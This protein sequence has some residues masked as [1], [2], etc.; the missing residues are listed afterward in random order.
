MCIAPHKIADVGFVACRECWQ[1]R[2]RKVDDWVG[3]CIA[4]G[5]TA[6]AC[7]AVTLTY[8]DDLSTGAKDHQR[9]TVLTYSDVQKY[10]KYLRA[11]GY[12]VRYMA[13]GE[14]GSIK[15]RAHWHIILYWQDRVPEHEIGKRF[16]QKHWPHGFSYWEPVSAQSI[17]Y[18]C[19]YIQKDMG[20]DLRQG[21]MAM[22]KKP[23]LGDA[24]FRELA[25]RY[26]ENGIAPQD[27]FYS[28]PEVRRVPHGTKGKSAK[29]FHANSKP[30]Q[31]MMSGKTADNFLTY[32]VEGWREKFNDE[33]PR[34][35]VVWAWLDKNLQRYVDSI[36]LPR[37]ERRG[38]VPK[39]EKPP[40]GGSAVRFDEGA[41]CFY[42]D[43]HGVRMFYSYDTE[44]DLGWH[45]KI[46]PD[47]A[48]E[49][50]R[51]VQ[52]EAAQNRYLD[53]S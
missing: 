45:E 42:S 17:R 20:D 40:F 37:F 52:S 35:P 5:R 10:L 16:N 38:Y 13:V 51:Q 25:A 27:L 50:L 28:F 46:R 48:K 8:G 26:V 21:H 12:P 19:K 23:P 14:Y 43:V 6:K 11:D 44:G 31:F 22:S 53:L 18:N 41:N 24:Y 4:E 9:M 15:S 29:A 30:I 47:A 34:S 39:P 1:C 7:H 3:R 36:S 49:R 33:P 32:F 2:E